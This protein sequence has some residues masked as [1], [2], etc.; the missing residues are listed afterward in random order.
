[1]SAQHFSTSNHQ[2]TVLTTR[3]RVRTPKLPVHALCVRTVEKSSA[4][5][6]IAGRLI[7]VLATERT[8]APTGMYHTQFKRNLGK[9]LRS[10]AHA[11]MHRQCRDVE[12]KPLS[13]VP[14]RL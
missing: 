5:Y 9:Y 11:D 13:T 7:A 2:Q 12:G 4:T 1:M 3:Q 14:N 8:A 6:S 10:V